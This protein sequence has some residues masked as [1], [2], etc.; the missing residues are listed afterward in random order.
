MPRTSRT[1]VL[2]ALCFLTCPSV[3]SAEKPSAERGKAILTSHAL[4]PPLWSRK[5]YDNAWKHWGVKERPSDYDA[6]FRAHYGLHVAP[7]DNKGLPLGLQE[8]NGLLSRG[9]INNCLLCH[10]STIAGQTLIGLANSALDLQALFHDLSHQDGFQI[11][12]GFDFSVARGTVDPI[13]PLTFLISFRDAELNVRPQQKLGYSSDVASDPPAW[14]Q[15]KRKKTRDW[16]GNV[17]VRSTR[18]DMVNLLN[19]INGPAYIKKQES[20]F[21]DIGAFLMTIEAPKYPFSIDSTRAERG[22]VVYE[23][24]CVKCHGSKTSYPNRIVPFDVIGTDRT[25]ADAMTPRLRENFNASWFA[26]EL[27]PEGKPYVVTET[28]G[29]QAPPLDGI[30]ATAPYFHNSSA[31]TLYHVLNSKARPRVFTRSYRTDKEEYDTEKIG[32]R[33]KV[34]DHA[35]GEKSPWLERRNVYDTDQRGRGN[36]GHTFGDSLS[37]AERG[38]LLEYLKTL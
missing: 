18:V 3:W 7:F 22:Q 4:N 12:E 14:W 31:P 34:L 17:D 9:I 19:P 6:A 36:G 15:L 13:N 25:L 33:V 20:A 23:S 30:W 24:K 35:P 16:T 2:L 5:A 27:G 8:S 38:D 11:N 26:R 29:Y 28:D 1:P 10:A 21:A 37:E 32:W